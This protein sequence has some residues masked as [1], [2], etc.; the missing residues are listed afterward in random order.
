MPTLAENVAKLELDVQTAHDIV[1]GPASGTGS[2]VTTEGG[3][4]RTLAKLVADSEVVID[5]AAQ[6]SALAADTGAS[7]I[8]T[9]LGAAGAVARTQAGKNADVVSVKDFGAAGDGVT[10]DTAAISAAIAASDGGT[11]FFPK[12]TYLHG[13]IVVSSASDVHLVGD[14]KGVTTLKLKNGANAH[15]I[16]YLSATNCSVRNITIDQNSLNQTGGHGVR[17]GGINGFVLDHVRI[18]NCYSYGIGMQAGTNTRVLIANFEIDT[19]G[20]DGIDIKDYDLANDEIVICSGM[21]RNHGTRELQQVGIDV[22]GPA[23]VGNVLVTCQNPDTRGFRFRG[24]SVQGRAGEGV[25]TNLRVKATAAAAGTG[26]YAL[27]I[28][29]GVKDYAISNVSVDG[30]ALI[31]V[32]NGAGGL[33]ENIAGKNLTGA[34][35]LSIAG[36]SVRIRNLRIDTCQRGI[37][38][39][40]GATDNSISGFEITGASSSEAI[41]IQASADGNRLIEGEIESGKA[42]ADLASNTTIRDVKN[43]ETAANLASGDLLVD[44]IGSRTVVLSHGLKVAPNVEDIALSVARSTGNPTDYRVGLLHVDSVSSS[45][46]TVRAVVTTASATAGAAVK[47]VAAVRAKRS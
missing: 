6:A 16:E 12:G 1:H 30:G 39:E 46:V 26:T 17:L 9:K 20:Q 7:L 18:F 37:D 43:W 11:V 28:S 2:T 31:G 35:A 22:R 5:G 8:G 36:S 32:I 42:I 47:I 25:I 19:C 23:V 29:A 24:S 3:T 15:A 21:I 27:D 45:A 44:S 14:G 33:L 13:G 38:F 34:E 41:R 40:A 10:D 4:V